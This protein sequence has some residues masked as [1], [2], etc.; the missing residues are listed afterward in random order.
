MA[1]PARFLITGGA[2]LLVVA[3]CGSQTANSALSPSQSVSPAAPSAS[4]PERSGGPHRYYLDPVTGQDSGADQCEK[5]VA[6]RTGPWICPETQ[7][8][9]G[10]VGTGEYCAGAGCWYRENDFNGHFQSSPNAWGYEDKVLGQISV[11]AEWQLVGGK[12]TTKPFR[13]FNSTATTDVIFEGDLLNAA[14]GRPGTQDPGA[15]SLFTA[16]NVPALTN[17]NWLPNGYVS[18]DKSNWD[19]SQVQE[20]VWHAPGYPG[21]WY[22]YV[23]SI[24]SHKD[25]DVYRFA[26]TGDLPADPVQAGWHAS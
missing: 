5:P 12:T 9:T 18:F 19:H 4:G 7:G 2:M 10:Q 24:C 13:Y 25:D 17:K 26:H 23:K 16:G 14:P 15:F 20:W 8:P 1:S 22:F 6:E 11:L 3:A 21:N